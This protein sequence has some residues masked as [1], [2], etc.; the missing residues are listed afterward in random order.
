VAVK[1]NRFSA[2]VLLKIKPFWESNRLWFGFYHKPELK[3]ELQVEPII[4][5]KLIKL[6]LVNQ[7]IE[8]RIKV[9]LEEYVMLPN[10]DDLLFWDFR[11]IS[12]SPL[13]E[14]SSDSDYEDNLQV[15]QTVVALN[16]DNYSDSYAS[17]HES[18]SSAALLGEALESSIAP[19]QLLKRRFR[20]KQSRIREAVFTNED[21]NGYDSDEESG[22]AL[23]NVSLSSSGSAEE[24]ERE[25][26]SLPIHPNPNPK[27]L[28]H[29]SASTSG[30]TTPIIAKP[31]M[32][33]D[34]FESYKDAPLK[35]SH[36]SLTR[37]L[38]RPISI[39][40]LSPSVDMAETESSRSSV[41]EANSKYVEQ[42]GNTVFQLGELVRKNGLDKKAQDVATSVAI[43]ATPAVTFASETT[44]NYTAKV[45]D[46]AV[47]VGLSAIERLGLSPDK[48]EGLETAGTK[49]LR[50][51]SS[52][53]WNLLGLKVAT[54]PPTETSSSKTESVR[55][56]KK[57]RSRM[58]IDQA[59]TEPPVN[60]SSEN[61]T[62]QVIPESTGTLS[63]APLQ[64]VSS[65]LVQS[66]SGNAHVGGLNEVKEGVFHL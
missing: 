21:V 61:V 48:E 38:R 33:H 17:D 66:I 49:T 59:S 37:T 12:G 62:E 56:V 34:T 41:S 9:A 40:D 7:V 36:D 13:T 28:I 22:I 55:Q 58:L 3:L 18:V 27:N 53:T 52:I 42:L 6:H 29:T 16:P 8:R 51:K 65:T 10:M 60:S 15:E 35:T 26:A 25:S 44:K 2:R 20:Q 31:S 45:Q 64:G 23:D 4:S 46:A 39:Q 5:N 63:P 1:I 11:D 30:T 47:A 43:Y 57:K 54:K 32:E 19:Q 14:H 50:H 24:T